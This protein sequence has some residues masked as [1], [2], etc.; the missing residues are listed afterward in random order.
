MAVAIAKQIPVF[1]PDSA[2]ARLRPREFDRAEFVEG[3]RYELIDGVL[4]VSPIPLPNERDPNDELGHLLR[5]YLENNSQE[6]TLN[7]TLPEHIIKVKNNRR[8]PDRVIWASLGRKPRANETPTIV[9]EFVSKGKR[10][11][12]RD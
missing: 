7:K 6:A 4:I 5:Q 11:R 10:N 3:F 8:R 12:R 2:G 1:G 9:V